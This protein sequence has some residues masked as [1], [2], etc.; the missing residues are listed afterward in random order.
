MKKTIW[1]KSLKPLRITLHGGRVL[2]LGPNK[3]GQIAEDDAERPAVKKL[4]ESGELVLVDDASAEEIRSLPDAG[5]DVKPDHSRRKVVLP[6]GG[7]TA[8][9]RR[10]N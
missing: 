3:T 8:G 9:G 1:N 6:S 5:H 2:H 7:R 10:E 4:I